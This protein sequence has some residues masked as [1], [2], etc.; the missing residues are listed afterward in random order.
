MTSVLLPVALAVLAMMS[1][2]WVV[3]LVRQDA[4]VADSFWGLGF[5]VVAWTATVV[6]GS[7]PSARAIC[8]VACVTVWSLRLT[9]YLTWRNWGEPE[10][11]RYAAMRQEHGARF[12]WV[13]AFTVFLLQGS[14]LLLVALP[15]VAVATAAPSP[16]GP[17]DGLGLGLFVVGLFFEAVGDAQLARFK[18]DPKNRGAVLDHGLWRYS[19]HPNYFGDALVWWGLST[20]AF[21]NGAWW[22]VGSPVLMTVLLLKISG[23]A[24]LERTISERRPEYQDYVRRTRAFVP[25]FP[26]RG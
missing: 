9:I 26:R 19:R 16:L 20:L 3:S 4:G 2:A 15:L 1:T 7:A 11:R 18:A 17:V 8:M 22:V 10:D 12:W 6:H 21:A 24:L 23:V 14:L 5:A 13:S 25:W